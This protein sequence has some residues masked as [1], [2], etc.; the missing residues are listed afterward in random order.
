MDTYIFVQ[1]VCI[2]IIHSPKNNFTQASQNNS[3]T[4]DPAEQE[5]VSCWE[6]GGSKQLLRHTQY[7]QFGIAG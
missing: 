4:L 5:F 6:K 1:K 2:N 7:T 3:I